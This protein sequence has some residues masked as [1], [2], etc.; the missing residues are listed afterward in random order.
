MGHPRVPLDEATTMTIVRM[1]VRMSPHVTRR[2][3]AD[4]VFKTEEH[5]IQSNKG[6]NLSRPRAGDE[7]VQQE[8]VRDCPKENVA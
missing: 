5:R 2:W 8:A 3:Q 4:S 1:N 7:S 6:H